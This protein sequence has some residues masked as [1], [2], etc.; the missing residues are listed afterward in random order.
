MLQGS[1]NKEPSM[2]FSGTYQ[3]LPTR[4]IFGGSRS[5]LPAAIEGL[6]IRQP[7]VLSS[8]THTAAVVEVLTA[9]CL[10][11]DAVFYDAEMHTPVSVTERA[12][13]FMQSRG[14]DGIVA[15]GGGSVIGL[16]K[17][18]ALRTDL[19]QIVIP[20]T[21]AGSE[22]TNILGE[23]S[24][25]RKVTQRGAEIQPETVIY[26]VSLYAGL[27]ASLRVTSALN[28]LSHAVEA[29]YAQDRNPISSL[30][31]VEAARRIITG[32]PRIIR[33][34]NDP[35]DLWAVMFGAH[36]AAT[37]LGSVAMSLHHKICH[38]LGGTFGLPHAQTH[39]VMLP[40]V[41]AYNAAAARPELAPLRDMLPGD[42]LGAALRTFALGLGAPPS[43]SSLGFSRS[44]AGRTAQLVFE[45]AYG[46]PR[47]PG[48]GSLERMIEA[49]ADG[50]DPLDDKLAE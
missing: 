14:A 12:M 39:S 11:E 3:P 47:T 43:L 9:A 16:S 6:G 8:R 33:G 25:G 17:A 35:D 18:L 42:E 13:T 20:S 1:D 27:P 10:G 34:S 31:A 48:I 37:V 40:Y 38:V 2:T 36:L 26:D 21:F 30:M 23:T 5:S 24:G 49:A 4:V 45:A 22:M 50:S 28:A 44:E 29:L 15:L 46:N 41:V 7:V 19:P 32:L